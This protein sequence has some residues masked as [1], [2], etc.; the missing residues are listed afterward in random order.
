MNYT[1]EE[2]E[3]I[4]FLSAVREPI[5]RTKSAYLH[6]ADKKKYPDPNEWV[7]EKWLKILDDEEMLNGLNIPNLKVFKVER[8][9]DDA[10]EWAQDQGLTYPRFVRANTWRQRE[11]A[12]AGK[13]PEVD[14][15]KDVQQA[16]RDKFKWTLDMFYS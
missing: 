13:Y 12:K 16:I 1:Q 10:T 3:D 15:S 9:Q 2:I 6:L 7:K 14:L 8:I 4:T 5:A 11:G